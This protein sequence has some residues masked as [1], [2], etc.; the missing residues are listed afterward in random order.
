MIDCSFDWLIDWLKF[1]TREQISPSSS[2]I[3]SVF[4]LFF[5]GLLPRAPKKTTVHWLWKN[6][7]TTSRSNKRNWRPARRQ[8]RSA[9]NSS[10][11]CCNAIRPCS[12]PWLWSGDRPG[13]VLSASWI[14]RPVAP[15]V[16]FPASLAITIHCRKSCRRR[17][18]WKNATGWPRSPLLHVTFQ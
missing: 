16:N 7:V 18:T 10:S 3:R 11:I 5:P 2:S 9:L 12:R 1:Y 4:L 17:L 13:P 6:A 15:A 14:A 8:R